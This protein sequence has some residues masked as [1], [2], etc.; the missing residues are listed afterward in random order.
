MSYELPVLE[1]R[2]RFL[3]ARDVRWPLG[4]TKHEIE[5]MVQYS[6]NAVIV[7]F[8]Q[9]FGHAKTGQYSGK[10][11]GISRARIVPRFRMPEY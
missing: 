3:P 4:A 9:V 5:K 8:G 1:Y 10:Y 7:V 11:S 2:R 6:G